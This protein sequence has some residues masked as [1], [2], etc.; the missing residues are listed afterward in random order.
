MCVCVGKGGSQWLEL[1]SKDCLFCSFSV[2]P[3][4]KDIYMMLVYFNYFV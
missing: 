3:L 1:K 2:C 4:L